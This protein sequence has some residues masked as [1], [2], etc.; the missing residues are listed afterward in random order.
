M[1]D[2]MIKATLE[3]YIYMKQGVKSFYLPGGSVV[4]VRGQQESIDK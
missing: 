1:V 3:G 4:V 2:E